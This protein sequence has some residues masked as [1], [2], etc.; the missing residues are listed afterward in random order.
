[1]G[2]N[3]T[4]TYM[5]EWAFDVVISRVLVVGYIVYLSSKW[6][7]NQVLLLT[8]YKAYTDQTWP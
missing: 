5:A 2:L 8:R 6:R 3:R 4:S 1:M 7:P